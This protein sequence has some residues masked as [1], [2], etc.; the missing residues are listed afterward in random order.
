MTSKFIMVL[1][2]T[3]GAGGAAFA[4]T[5]PTGSEGGASGGATTGAAGNTGAESFTMPQGWD[6]A[7]GTALFSDTTAGTAHSKEDITKNWASLS[8]EDKKKVQDHCMT[9][10]TGTSTTGT[11]GT[12]GATGSA[13]TTGAAGGASTTG[14]ADATKG[15]MTHASIQQICDD[16]K[17]M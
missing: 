14:T 3:L 16:I 10:G 17:G 13:G 4:Q 7:I 2:F 8:A 11:T 5:A 9:L 12:T 15:G 1:A 6:G